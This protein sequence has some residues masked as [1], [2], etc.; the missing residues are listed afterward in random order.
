MA[1]KWTIF[2]ITVISIAHKRFKV[3]PRDAFREL[4]QRKKCV[5]GS[6]PAQITQLHSTPHTLDGF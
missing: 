5:C 1:T 2:F 4:K 6:D 3:L